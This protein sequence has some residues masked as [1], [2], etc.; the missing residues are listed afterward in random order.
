MT[1]VVHGWKEVLHI[2]PNRQLFC[3]F[4]MNST[5]PENLDVWILAGQS[6][7]E[8]VG[9]LAL[10]LPPSERVWSFTSAGQW[11]VATEPLHRFWESFTPVHQNLIRPNLP[12]AR[13]SLS[14]AELAVLIAR[15]RRYG[16]GLGLAFGQAMAAALDRPIGLLPCAHGGTSLDQWSPDLKHEGGRS[17]Y[18]A[19]FERIR[20]A[21]GTL[22]G[23]LW[24]QGESEGWDPAQSATYQPR[25]DVWIARLRKDL[26]LP[27]FPV[28]A[29]QIGRTTLDTPKADAWNQVQKA[30]VELPDRVPF[31]AVTSA[32]DLPLVDCIHLNSAGLQRLGRRLARLAL[33]TSPA[34]RLLHASHQP[35]PP[36]RGLVRLTFTGV[37]G[38][39]MP[40]DNMAGFDVLTASGQPHPVNHVINAFP[41]PR[42]PTALHVRINI[43]LQPGEQIGYGQ[44]LR[45]YCNVTDEADMPLCAF[46]LPVP[47]AG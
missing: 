26:G 16:A 1:G 27:H 5:K 21:G 9:E 32:I 12:E 7:M 23:L 29:V 28:L 41:D 43:P 2:S 25:F 24:Y 10:S 15:E 4:H 47:L 46:R 3:L 40:A 13:K 38:K 17:L 8:G 33:G 14:D 18:G 6:N 31:T 30:L 39:W 36:D 34:P 37:T 35:E 22:R 19:M 11:E 45:P 42:D 44:G 20:R